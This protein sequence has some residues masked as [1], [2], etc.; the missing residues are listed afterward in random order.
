M[1]MIVQEGIAAFAIDQ[2]RW[3]RIALRPFVKAL[4]RTAASGGTLARPDLWM[5]LASGVFHRPPDIEQVAMHVCDLQQ[6]TTLT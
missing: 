3:N 6:C 5:N 2:F 1:L 4:I